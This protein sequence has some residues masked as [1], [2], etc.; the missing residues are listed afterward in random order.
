MILVVFDDDY[1][2]IRLIPLSMTSFLGVVAS[3]SELSMT[4]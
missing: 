3:F 2:T 1:S 4:I